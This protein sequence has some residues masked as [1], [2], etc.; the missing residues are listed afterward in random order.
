MF[1]KNMKKQSIKK[2]AK[3]VLVIVTSV[4]VGSFFDTTLFTADFA[5]ETIPIK[6]E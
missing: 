1:E 2:L 5:L 4:F 3:Q 6:L